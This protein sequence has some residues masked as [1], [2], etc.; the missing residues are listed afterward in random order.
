M[1][2]RVASIREVPVA[3]IWWLAV[4]VAGLLAGCAANA[5]DRVGM[6]PASSSVTRASGESPAD[7]SELGRPLAPSPSSVPAPTPRSAGTAAFADVPYPFPVQYRS[8]ESQGLALSMAYMDVKPDGGAHGS[9]V[10]LHGKNFSGAYWEATA[11]A[12]VAAGFRVVMPDQIGFGKSSKPTEYQYSFHA[13]AAHTRELL[14]SLE[15]DRAHVV[16]HSMG[17]M[18]A[19]RF[20]LMFPE[21]SRSL[22]LVNPIGLE[23][24]AQKIGY[25]DIDAWVADELSKGVD[26]AREYMKQNYFA[27]AWKSEYEPL[28]TIQRTAIESP[29]RRELALVSAKTYDMI[30]TQ[31]VLDDFPR[32]NVATLLIMGQRDR[33]AV[34]KAWASPKVRETLGDYP[35]LGREAARAIPRAKLV[36]LP[37]LGHLPQVEAPDVVHAKLRDFLCADR[38]C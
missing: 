21:Q 15:I 7:S 1:N 3:M 22:V 20:A 4:A 12:L 24:Y 5:N 18:L 17:G 28:L 16:G 38:Q 25:V 34:G 19:T 10:L 33:T 29:A 37:A 31:P 11:R 2:Q 30:L 6:P 13:L 32:V 36:E 27:G 23:N 26:D 14:E 8:F 9:V 35:R